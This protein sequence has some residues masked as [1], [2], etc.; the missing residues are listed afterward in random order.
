[1]RPKLQERIFDRTSKVDFQTLKALLEKK[2]SLAEVEAGYYTFQNLPSA[3]VAYS[4]YL[5]LNLF[6]LWNRKKKIGKRFYSIREIVEELIQLR[7]EIVHKAYLKP[8]FDKIEVDRYRKA[9]ELAGK[10]IVDALEQEKGF[11]IDLNKYL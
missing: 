10:S 7:H 1:M 9:V 6:K 2:K 3:N 5:E 8:D 11:R 4:E